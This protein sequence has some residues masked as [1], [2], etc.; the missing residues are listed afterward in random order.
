M[1]ENNNPNNNT[2]A[3][4]P[5]PDNQ[6][7]QATPNPVQQG[8]PG[9]PVN[10]AFQQQGAPGAPVNPAFQQQ[11]APGAP[12][13]PAFQQQGAPGA[14]VNPAF[15]QK[16]APINEKI[17]QQMAA[18][19]IKTSKKLSKKVLIL[20]IAIAVVVLISI[21]IGGIL[22]VTN[23]GKTTVDMSKYYEIEVKGFN[24]YA[25]A[26]VNEI[27]DPYDDLF[28]N[29]K[30]DKDKLTSAASIYSFLSDIDKELSKSSNISNGDTIECK[31]TYSKEAA[32]NLKLKIKNDTIKLKVKDLEEGKKVD[33]FAGLEVT[34]SGISPDGR[35]TVNNN[36]SDD[37]IRRV[38]YSLDKRSNL[39]NGDKV[40]VTASYDEEYAIENGYAVQSDT[41]E[42]TVSG[43]GTYLD[44]KTTL[45]AENK[46]AFE[47]EFKDRVD[48]I[49]ASRWET[50]YNKFGDSV[51]GGEKVSV[52]TP[53]L[54]R[55]YLLSLKDPEKS[56]GD[57]NKLVMI[58]KVDINV[59]AGQY[60]SSSD[61]FGNRT[62]YV[63]VTF[64]EAGISDEG[65]FVDTP[66]SMYSGYSADKSLE[67]L[68]NDL[69]TIN[70]T[71]YIVS[72]WK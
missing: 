30:I 65:I 22:F 62:G 46:A 14:P 3:S 66:T 18:M 70:K 9:T 58:C 21:G 57:Y 23:L 1:N 31:F 50:I 36:S 69:V 49:L 68:E 11:G 27:L 53:T 26:S 54:E 15:Q 64:S 56:S 32:K 67:T 48:S 20:I 29:G 8:A 4:G 41:K 42:Y 60:S 37:F 40:V 55:G 39:K 34:F 43:L 71:N 47:K 16:G 19:G 6:S 7:A 59:K 12:V 2:Q 5:E 61:K 45:S 17:Q 28:S 13:N 38:R 72:N 52:G 24:G 33:P 35:A 63:A 51:Y 10:P 44:D 25:K